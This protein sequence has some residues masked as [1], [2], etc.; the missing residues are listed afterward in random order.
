MVSTGARGCHA[1][2]LHCRCGRHPLSDW[3]L[4]LVTATRTWRRR[5]HEVLAY[6]APKMRRFRIK[7]SPGDRVKIEL[8]PYDLTRGRIVYGFK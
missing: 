7:I 8:W 5:G 1:A 4:G 6:T 2:C 3:T